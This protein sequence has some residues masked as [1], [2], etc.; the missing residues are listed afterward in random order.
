MMRGKKEV[1]NLDADFRG[2][3]K[4]GPNPDVEAMWALELDEGETLDALCG[5]WR[6]VQLRDGHRFSTDDVLAAWYG[7]SWCPSARTVLELGSGMGTAGMIA[8]WR[9]PG[10]RFV[11][12]E[13]QEASVALARKSA[14]YNGLTQERYDIRHGD[15]RDPDV[16][17][18]ALRFDLILGTPPYWPPEAGVHGDHPQKVACRFELRGSVADYAATASRH[19]APGGVF[20]CVFP[21]RPDN[22]HQR[23]IDGAREV[24]LVLVRWRPVTFKEGDEPLVGLY[25]FMRAD[26]LPAALHDDPWQ[27]PTITIRMKDGS[28]HPEYARIKLAFGFPP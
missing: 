13:A 7:T 9:L 3:T 1:R 24:G 28:V 27:E 15:L 4:P 6:L 10:A 2:W 21:C 19:L 26:D 14:R 12:V 18:P 23:A 16:L 11:T 17:D 8:A 5:H 20:A 25:L 22:Q